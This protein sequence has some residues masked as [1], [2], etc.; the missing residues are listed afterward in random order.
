ME[1]GY[2]QT[3][4]VAYFAI[5]TGGDPYERRAL[6]RMSINRAV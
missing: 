1:S 5:S 4:A 6:A 3:L 2:V